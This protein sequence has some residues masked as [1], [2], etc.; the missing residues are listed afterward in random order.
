MN[1]D[2]YLVKCQNINWINKEFNER[3]FEQNKEK[4]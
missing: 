2:I 4:L 3:L 1:D